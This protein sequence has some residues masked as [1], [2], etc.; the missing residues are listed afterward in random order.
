M[1]TRLRV[2]AG[3]GQIESNPEIAAESD[4][5]CL[6][7]SRER[8][9][10][11]ERVRQAERQRVCERREELGRGVGKR[12][13]RQRSEGDPID[14]VLSAVDGRLRQQDQVS[15]RQ[16]YV[17]VG[18]VEPGRRAL[19]RPV[20]RRIQVAHAEGNDRERCQTPERCFLQQAAH[21]RQLLVFPRKA[22]GDVDRVNAKRPCFGGGKYGAVEACRQQ[23]D[24]GCLVDHR[25]S[26]LASGP[27]ALAAGSDDRVFG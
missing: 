20:S 23:H 7:K 1:L 21:H 5:V 9:G 13:A 10:D 15:S 6:V 18:R 27:S 16:I 11:R 8:R 17:L 24:G 19:Q 12:I 22:R 14:P 3:Q 4:H 25:L 26:I 2:H